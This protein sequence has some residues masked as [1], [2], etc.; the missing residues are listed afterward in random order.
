MSEACCLPWFQ[1]VLP[2]YV[3]LID[4][5][6]RSIHVALGLSLALL[7][8]PFKKT[9]ATGKPCPWWD[10][11]II[12]VIFASNVNIFLKTMDIYTKPGGGT[13]L[14]LILGIALLILVMEMARRTVG[15]I[16]PGLLILLI[17]YI[18][19]SPLDARGL[20]D[21]WAVVAVSGELHLLFSPR[22]LRER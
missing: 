1:L 21:A 22:H 12:G 14:D 9:V 16:I 7:A 20:E 2:V 19:V 11:V 17:I 8:F 13:T 3:H 6:L 18:F 4:L 15:W 5:Q 10:F